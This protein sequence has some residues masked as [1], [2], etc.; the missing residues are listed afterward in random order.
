MALFYTREAAANFTNVGA[1][2]FYRTSE[3][4]SFLVAINRSNVY[5]PFVFTAMFVNL[6]YTLILAPCPLSHW[7]AQMKLSTLSID[8]C[9]RF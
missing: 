7:T 5:L 3:S 4:I 6:T 9:C 8:K 1:L 2:T